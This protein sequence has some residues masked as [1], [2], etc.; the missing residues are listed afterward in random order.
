[1]I[2]GVGPMALWSRFGYLLDTRLLVSVVWISK[3]NARPGLFWKCLEWMFLT[4]NDL[5]LVAAILCYG[6]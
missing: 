6:N 1:M 3:Y 4:M 5:L 2:M